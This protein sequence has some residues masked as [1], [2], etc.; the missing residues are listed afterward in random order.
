MNLSR[1]N[2]DGMKSNVVNSS[3]S[4]KTQIIQKMR[5]QYGLNHKPSSSEVHKEKYNL[6]SNK[7]INR[8]LSGPV[9]APV[10]YPVSFSLSSKYRL[11]ILDQGNLGSCVVNAYSGIINSLYNINLSRLY[12]YYNARV[13]TGNDPTQDT[14]L[15]LLQSHPILKSFGIVPESRWPYSINQFSVIPPYNSTYKIANT[16]SYPVV[17]SSIS[18]T[19]NSIKNVLTNGGFVMLGI[20]IY[21]SF[22]TTSVSKN[23]IIPMPN[24]NREAFIGGH[25][26]HIVGWCKY[27]GVT[28]YII[29]NSW[30]L[31]WGNDGNPNP[32]SNFVNNGQNGGFAYIPTAYILSP[33]I[34]FELLGVSKSK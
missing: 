24:S 8:M 23:G 27:N 3:S 21:S 34:S 32:T 5:E 26:I 18:Q 20:Y 7:N 31:R 15:D 17:F 9:T 10:V 30:G 4:T 28:Y 1:M 19:D 14:G 12:S 22:M 16:T 2:I 11:N 13:G 25:C 33:N 29:R 6:E